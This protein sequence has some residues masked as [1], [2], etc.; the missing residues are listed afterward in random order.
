MIQRR[1]RRSHEAL[2]EAAMSLFRLDLIALDNNECFADCRG[3]RTLADMFQHE[4][5]KQGAALDLLLQG[6]VSDVC[7]ELF[8][9]GPPH[10]ERLAHFLQRWFFERRTVRAISAEMHLNPHY[11]GRAIKAQACALA[12]HRFLD[13]AQ[14]EDPVSRSLGLRQAVEQYQERRRI[15]ASRLVGLIRRDVSCDVA[16]PPHSPETCQT[17]LPFRGSGDEAGEV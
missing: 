5:F 15:A 9:A 17:P 4:I 16:Q 14:A 6:A 7:S 10:E 2:V 12:A 3:V 13:L 1:G 8:A 11:A